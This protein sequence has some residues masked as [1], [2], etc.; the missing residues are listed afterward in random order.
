MFRFT[1]A[2]AVAAMALTGCAKHPAAEAETS[3]AFTSGPA[4][5]SVSHISSRADD[6]SSVFLTVDGNDAGMLARGESKELRM[7]PGKHKVGGYV[8]TLFGFGQVTIQ[9]VEITT[10]AGQVKRVAYS[11]QKDKPS[12]AEEPTTAG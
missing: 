3:Q 7:A 2:A 10:E 12:F 9:P 11:V 1:L 4:Q 5:V 8:R 6:G